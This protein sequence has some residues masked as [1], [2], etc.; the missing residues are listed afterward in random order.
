MRFSLSRRWLVAAMLSVAA[1]VSW[2]ILQEVETGGGA[3][4]QIPPHEV[5]YY[6]EDFQ[7]KNMDR[8]GNL[9]DQVS[10]KKMTHYS[11][12]DTADLV[13]PE[14]VFYQAAGEQWS[15]TA[16]SGEIVGQGDIVRFSGAVRLT[17]ESQS[18]QPRLVV[19]ADD[20]EFRV[21]E[22]LAQTDHSVE[23]IYDGG[24]ARAVG[25]RVDVANRYVRLL[26]NVRGR[27]VHRQN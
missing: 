22:Q 12:N 24:V 13:Q 6:L 23:I 9:R 27:Y 2:W 4:T 19:N 10:A 18:D 8:Q 1:L 16:Q 26:S 11:D 25:L 7:V 5:D 14:F 15:I 3:L 21:N 20:M 17:R